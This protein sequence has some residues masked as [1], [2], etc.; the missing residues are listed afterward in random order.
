MLR[1][2]D[3]HAHVWVS[4]ALVVG[5]RR[6]SNLFLRREG[7]PAFIIAVGG[8]RAEDDEDHKRSLNAPPE[9]MRRLWGDF[10]WWG[11]GLGCGGRFSRDSQLGGLGFLTANSDGT[12][13][14]RMVLKM[15]L[16]IV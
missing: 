15:G 13:G 9:A 5:L 8:A 10:G 6:H 11:G 7:W 14:P 12:F 3:A 2:G 16:R 1:E 4:S